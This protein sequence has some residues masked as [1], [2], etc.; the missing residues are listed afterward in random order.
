MV[1]YHNPKQ[2]MDRIH[3][4]LL[5][6]PDLVSHPAMYLGAKLQRKTFDDTTLVWD[7][8][9]QNMS[10]KVSGLLRHTS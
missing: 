1:V 2:I 5:L 7:L 9:Q 10:D 4:I 3:S 8:V 6:K